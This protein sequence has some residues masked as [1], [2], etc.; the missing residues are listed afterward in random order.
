MIDFH[1]L[2]AEPHWQSEP[3]DL[4]ELQRSWLLHQDSLTKKLQQHFADFAVKV[5]FEGWRKAENA[6]NSC[7]FTA[8]AAPNEGKIWWREV[9]LYGNG[10]PIIFAQTL[11]PEATFSAFEQAFLTLNE[12][13]IGLWLFAQDPKRL[14]LKWQK[15]NRPP[16]H[17][18]A[19]RAVYQLNGYPLEIRELFLPDFDGFSS[20]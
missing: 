7:F 18:Y 12:T 2:L 1:Q 5:Q 11:I 10:K 3:T 8:S 20:I 15:I 19:R 14:S 4:T 6:K 9:L 13:P 17:Y 16:E